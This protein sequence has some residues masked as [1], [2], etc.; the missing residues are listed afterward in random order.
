[1]S[2]EKNKIWKFQ[3]IFLSF[4][5]YIIREFKHFQKSLKFQWGRGRGNNMGRVGGGLEGRGNSQM[6]KQFGAQ[7][8]KH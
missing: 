6:N 4:E 3:V 5:S 2:F 1:M 7:P 8:N